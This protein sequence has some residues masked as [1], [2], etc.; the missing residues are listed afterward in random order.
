[1][2]KEEHGVQE[3]EV[4]VGC[5]R[6]K[7]LAYQSITGV[8]KA[9]GRVLLNTTAQF[10]GLGT[11]GY[12]FVI[13]DLD[14]TTT[15]L[16]GPGHIMKLRYTPLQIRC[17]AVEEQQSMWHSDIEGF[18]SLNRLPVMVTG[19]H[20]MLA[21]LCACIKALKPDADIVY[22]MTDAA[23]LPMAF[24]RT[25]GHLKDLGLLKA[26]VTCGNAFGGDY[27]A[28]NFYTG[29]ITA[30]EVI[31]CDAAIIGMGPGITGTGTTYGFSGIEQGYIIDGINTL[32]G[33][34]VVVP[35]LS[36]ADPR[37]RHK[38]ISHHTITVLKD[39]AKTSALLPIPELDGDRRSQLDEQ[40]KAH[41][42]AD[43]HK[44]VYKNGRV[45]FDAVKRFGLNT[46]TMGRGPE[47]DPEFFMAMGAAAMA[48]MDC[49]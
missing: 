24:S 35:R 39:I 41:G 44:V 21:P 47:D 12:H 16:S 3:L 46:T 18:E 31:K 19:L 32:G 40:L 1:V 17:L 13:A 15:E 23:A 27:E 29:I 6:E 26:T 30:R 14:N 49:L 28:V 5:S 10:L 11:G 4:T 43:R 36:F 8:L 2:L 25:V 38:G 42:I 37:A 20:S 22:I 7:A 48:V 34:P 9:G 33:L 45:V